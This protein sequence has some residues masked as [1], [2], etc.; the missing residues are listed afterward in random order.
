MIVQ[1]LF[2]GAVSIGIGTASLSA[3]VF[4]WEWCF[5]LRKARWIADRWGR[6]GARWFFATLGLLLILLGIAIS[7]GMAGADSQSRRHELPPEA[8][9]RCS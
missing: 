7:Y 5:E 1:D 9:L 8:L 4:N 2:V 6:Q 3:A